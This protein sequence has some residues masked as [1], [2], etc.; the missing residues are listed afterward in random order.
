MPQFNNNT[1]GNWT[2][3]L[4]PNEIQPIEEA[5]SQLAGF[6]SIKPPVHTKTK[7]L[8]NLP[9]TSKN[10]SGSGPAYPLLGPF[11]KSSDWNSLVSHLS[12]PEQLEDIHI[13]SLHKDEVLELDVIWVKN[14]VPEEVHDDLL[15]CFLLLEGS[16][17]CT[18]KNSEG[19]QR[20]IIMQ[21]GDF[22]ALEYGEHHDIKVT[23][24]I[25]A[26]AILQRLKLVA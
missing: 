14:Q 22:L 6:Y 8:D 9:L 1:L 3:G 12:G 24:P 11:S 4:E 7:I 23:S 18:I 16:C 26:K 5:L 13:E 20:E 10:P 25:P 19:H 21:A 15:E 2:E 17:C